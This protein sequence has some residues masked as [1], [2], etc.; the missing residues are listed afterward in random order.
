MKRA[1]IAAGTWCQD[2]E[3]FGDKLFDM[4]KFPVDMIDLEEDNNR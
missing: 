3:V 2:G 4:A 1:E